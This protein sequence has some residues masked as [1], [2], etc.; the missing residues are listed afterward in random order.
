MFRFLCKFVTMKRA[1][2]P[3]VGFNRFEYFTLLLCMAVGHAIV[4]NPF[5]GAAVYLFADIVKTFLLCNPSKIRHANGEH[6]FS[7]LLIALV[8]VLGLSVAFIYPAIMAEPKANYVSLFAIC[9]VVRDYLCAMPLIP[10]PGREAKSL[11]YCIAAQILF[12]AAAILIIS[13]QMKGDMLIMTGTFTVLTGI[14]KLLLPDPWI[15]SDSEA[16]KN[17]YENLASYKVFSNMNLYSTMAVNVGVMVFFFF[18]I[19]SG[20]K[21]FEL[22]NY[23]VLFAWML[24]VQVVLVV[25]AML[26]RKRWRGL[27]LAEFIAGIVIWGIGLSLMF[28]RGGFIF[29]TAGT[30]AWGAGLALI[31]SSVSKFYSDFEAVGKIMDDKDKEYD[32]NALKISNALTATVADIL[33]SVIMLVLLVVWTFV[34]PQLPDARA[35]NLFSGRLLLQLPA[36]LM[37]IAFFF[38]L[39]QPLDFRNREKLMRYI[40][41]YAGNG[42][43][44]E[45]LKSLFVRKYRTRYGIKALCTLARPFFRMKVSGIEHLRKKE[46]PSVF[47][48]NH[49]FIWGPVSAVIYLPTY[50]RPWI[51]NVMLNYDTASSEL[52]KSLAVIKKIIGKKAGTALINRVAKTVCSVLASFNPIPVVRG[53]SKDVMSTFELSVNALE[54]GDNILLFPEKPKELAGLAPDAD[55]GI[56]RNFYTGFVHI[57]KMYY[58]R[59]GKPLLFYPIYS[60]KDKRVLKIGEP[61]EYDTSLDS[62]EA[63]SVLSAAL[64]RRMEALMTE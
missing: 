8:A 33:S 16:L 50:F 42:R 11:M 64:Q 13:G 7:K 52:Q 49:G 43:V 21:E 58:D 29:D 22:E 35:A 51:H 44:R 23:R 41:D 24:A 61:V 18:I 36:I 62:R 27:G 28:N 6:Y 46:Y 15:P 63:K 2:V 17:S 10:G 4:G 39:R 5:Y 53:S 20:E 14:L 3:A 9:L 40:D 19:I 12:D 38:A 26:I 56:L 54:E 45:N 34:L 59:T 60:D 31:S 32:A 25:A 37:L 57:G 30:I 1:P 55:P 47:V 48:C